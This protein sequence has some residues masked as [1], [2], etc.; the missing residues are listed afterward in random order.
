MVLFINFHLQDMVDGL[1]RKLMSGD[2]LELPHLKDFYP[3]D[4]DLNG[5]LRR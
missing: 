5:A 4:E 3:L 2:V 1:G